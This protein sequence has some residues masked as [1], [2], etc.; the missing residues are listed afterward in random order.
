LP[1]HRPLS[2]FAHDDP[3]TLAHPHV[4]ENRM[5]PAR[6]LLLRGALPGATLSIALAAGLLRPASA[7]AGTAYQAARPQMGREA[8]ELLQALRTAHPSQSSEIRIVAPDIAEDGAN[9]F[10]ECSTTLPEVDGFVV[11]AER[12]PQQLVAA[13]WIAPEVLPELKTRIKLSRTSNVWVVVRSQGKYFK[14]YKMVKVTVGGCGVG[15]N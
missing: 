2:T 5:N 11:F 4:P 15:L 14:A 9:V 1:R 3:D 8:N 10:L 7:L 6:R 12:N 13:F